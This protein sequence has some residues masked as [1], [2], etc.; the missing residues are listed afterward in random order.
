MTMTTGG[1]LSQVSVGDAQVEMFSGG[2]GPPLLF[3]HGAGGNSGWQGYH[4]ELS[5]SYTVYVP[6]QAGFNGTERPDWLYT[7]YDL[8]LYNLEIVQALGIAQDRIMG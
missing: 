7:I 6:S 8:D 4:E 3:L 2:S 1:A 5:K